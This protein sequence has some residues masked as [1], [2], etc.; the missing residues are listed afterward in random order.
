MNTQELKT[1]IATDIEILKTLDLDIMPS[2]EY[3]QANGSL[4]LRVFF[5]I[6]GT[7]IVAILLPYL[8]HYI[9][10]WQQLMDTPLRQHGIDMVYLAVLALA[11]CA[12]A[13]LFIYSSLNHFVLI[14]SLLRPK[15]KTGEL[16]VKN[17]RLAGNI[18]YGIFAALVL[19]P[20]PFLESGMVLFVA[21]GAFFVSGILTNILIE[22]EINR[23]GLSTL[24]TLV[25]VYF[26]KDKNNPFPPDLMEK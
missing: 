4:F 1:A 22:M 25:K 17:I 21:F 15:L 8:C 16:L 24:F 20:A 10:Y 11:L 2:Q 18:A 19:I 23:V 13:F 14:D 6:Y 7:L 26:D 3:Y 12:F 9:Y 5:K